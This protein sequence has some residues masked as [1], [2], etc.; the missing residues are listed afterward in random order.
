MKAQARLL[1]LARTQ[2][3][4]LLARLDRGG[5]GAEAIAVALAMA[6]E[7]RAVPPLLAR[8]RNARTPDE[9]RVA[10]EALGA[11]RRRR[12]P[13]RVCRDSNA[14]IQRDA[15]AIERWYRSRDRSGNADGDARAH[16]RSLARRGSLRPSSSCSSA[17]APGSRSRRTRGR[18]GR[19]ADGPAA[20]TP[21]RSRAGGRRSTRR[22]PSWRRPWSGHRAR[23]PGA[24]R[25]RPGPVLVARPARRTPR[26][27]HLQI[28]ATDRGTPEDHLA[29]AE[30]LLGWAATNAAAGCRPL[31]G[32]RAVPG[33]C[34]RRSPSAPPRAR[35]TA[36][37]GDGPAGGGGALLAGATREAALAA[38]DEDALAGASEAEAAAARRPRRRARALRL[39][40]YA[41]AADGLR[42]GPGTC[43]ARPSALGRRPA[44]AP[45][46]WRSTRRLLARQPGD[47]RSCRRPSPPP[48]TPARRP[49]WPGLLAD[50][51]V[52]G[53]ARAG[54][55]PGHA[56]AS[57]PRRPGAGRRRTVRRPGRRGGARGRRRPGTSSAAS[58]WSRGAGR[59]G[60]PWT[61]AAAAFDRGPGLAP[62]GDESP[63]APLGHRGTDYS[64]AW[65]V[66]RA[67]ARILRIQQA[68]VAARRRTT[69][70]PGRTSATRCGSP[71]GTRR[72]WRPTTGPW[73]RS[74]ATRPSSA[75]GDWRSR[76]WAGPNEALAAFEAAARAGSRLR[77]G[78]PERGP[79]ALAGRPGRRGRAPSGRGGAPDA[80]RCRELDALPVPPGSRLANA[81]ID[82]ALR[83]R[84]GEPAR[85]M[86]VVPAAR[87]SA[88]MRS[89]HHAVPTRTH[90]R[91]VLLLVATG[92]AGSTG[93]SG[94]GREPSE[95]APF[96]LQDLDSRESSATLV[97][98]MR[99]LSRSRG[100]VPVA[101]PEE[102]RRPP[103]VLE[104][105]HGVNALADIP[106]LRTVV[107][108]GRHFRSAI[109]R[110]EVA[111]A[112][113]I[114]TFKKTSGIYINLKSEQS[115]LHVHD[116][117]EL[118][119]GA[120]L[121]KIL[122]PQTVSAPRD[123]PRSTRYGQRAAGGG[124]VP[125]RDAVLK[126]RYPKGDFAVRLR[127]LAHAGA[128]APRAKFLDEDGSI[129]H[130][131]LT[132]VLTEFWRR[133]HVDFDRIV[134][135]RQPSL[136]RRSGR[137]VPARLRRPR[138]CEAERSTP[139]VGPR[140]T[141]ASRS[142]WWTIEAREGAEGRRASR[143]DGRL[144][145]RR[146]WSG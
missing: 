9:R 115:Q 63:D 121:E 57:W 45:R 19:R 142:S 96:S 90:R 89:E 145:P 108:Q 50:L 55:P 95:K 140:T 119:E 30:A 59:R 51:E 3:D 136:P 105:A 132:V 75:T 72:P 65:R 97:E 84:H 139:E 40:R 34:P 138:S 76:P 104:E 134:R 103:W 106:F 16:I 13:A 61:R 127:E 74:P 98:P 36:S 42:S 128:V 49:S 83:W 88:P 1:D 116:A 99:G 94:R 135:R 18:R 7:R 10:A 118:P 68:L 110:Q 27:Q 52:E 37:A 31:D 79:A 44:R 4:L 85:R 113:E 60:R 11:T 26:L 120:A 102:P 21:P 39:G 17:S 81:H 58:G 112:T 6:G 35:T 87:R 114:T 8:Y 82:P 133:Y 48:A 70:S 33:G 122:A 24:A 2:P 141:P 41:E 109:R 143:R 146:G 77:R 117:E 101:P 78:P 80:R 29:L 32:R 62:R 43:A 73:R 69:G 28:G 14:E 126:R 130:R 144:R 111:A 71:G 91:L 25:G 20:A 123:H 124:Q 15:D 131:F 47:G 129:R 93:A 56:G 46:R 22:P 125:R 54:G 100:R 66:R 23:R 38:W 107:Y 53:T 86:H 137:I 64:A 67:L 5:R 12:A 92:L